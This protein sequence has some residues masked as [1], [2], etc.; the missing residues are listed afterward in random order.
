MYVFKALLLLWSIL[1]ICDVAAV[2]RVSVVVSTMDD[3]DKVEV[4]HESRGSL[5][6]P[7][8]NAVDISV[9]RDGGILKEVL[10]E[11]VEHEFP[12]LG[13][14][15]TVTYD[16]MFADGN[17]F[18]STQFRSDNKFEFILGKG[19]TSYCAEIPVESPFSGHLI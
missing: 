2:Q 6:T 19:E 17:R 14:R 3:A 15:V 9:D 13:D 12:Q 10:K 1:G 5:L 4:E 16:A 8:C 18:D 11:S 7:G